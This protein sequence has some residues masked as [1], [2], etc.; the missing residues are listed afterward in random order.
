MTRS[1][2]EPRRRAGPSDHGARRGHFCEIRQSYEQHV[3]IL[4]Q[5][6]PSAAPSILLPTYP[7]FGGGMPLRVDT[8]TGGRVQAPAPDGAGRVG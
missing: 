3:L 4:L 5:L 2:P 7:R 6:N 8:G 1:L